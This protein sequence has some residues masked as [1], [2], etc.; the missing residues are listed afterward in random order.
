M[1]DAERIYGFAGELAGYIKDGQNSLPE[2]TRGNVCDAAFA[3]GQGPG[4]SKMMQRDKRILGYCD[5]SFVYALSR[6]QQGKPSKNHSRMICINLVHSHIASTSLDES[7][8]APTGVPPTWQRAAMRSPREDI[9][10]S[11]TKQTAAGLKFI[12]DKDV[13]HRDLKAENILEPRMQRG[14][15]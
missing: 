4:T 7:L 2:E 5:L 14:D 11:V 10:K 1:V 13:V 8:G 12:H 15:G 6:F 9:V 3:E